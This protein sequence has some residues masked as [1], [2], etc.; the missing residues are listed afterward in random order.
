MSPTE[1]V[2][3]RYYRKVIKGWG[4]WHHGDCRIFDSDIC[5]CGLLHDLLYADQSNE[6]YPNYYKE[7]AKQ[8]K[9]IRDMREINQEK[10]A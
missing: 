5:T 6:L 4:I 1:R 10:K 8:D 9:K 7:A 3:A 2:K